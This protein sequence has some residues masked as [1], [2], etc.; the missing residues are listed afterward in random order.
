MN[1]KNITELIGN[2][3]HLRLARLFPN[4]EVYMK[5]EMNNPG[6][7]IKDRI[8]YYMLLEAK[9]R[10]ALLPGMAIV[11]PTSGNTGI[12]LALAGKQMGHQVTLVMP[13]HMSPE[14][15][16]IMEALGAKVMLT[17]RAE[18]M[19]GAIRKSE[20]FKEHFGA[21][22]PGQ[23]NNKA[24]PGAHLKTTVYEILEDFP[25]GIAAMIAAVGTGGHLTGIGKGLKKKNPGTLIIAV[26]PEESA[27]ISGK[28][29]GS[30]AIQGIGAGFIPKVLDKSLIDKVIT[31]SFG[32]AK[33]GM[34]ELARQE[35]VLGGISTGANV[36]ATKKFLEKHEG[37]WSK[38]LFTFAYDGMEK[39][40]SV[41]GM[42]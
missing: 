35:G 27:V 17:S 30:H 11:E 4:A 24:N 38:P 39:Y 26:E 8:A 1:I 3:P 25:D 13:E 10:G 7:S 33:E 32:E 40:L 21:F 31:V 16:K 6:G 29:P 36:M 12:G 34:L 42:F 28:Y 19:K 9:N 15:R 37:R 2:T 5:L 23:F 41:E 18:G 14:R 22:M 20:E